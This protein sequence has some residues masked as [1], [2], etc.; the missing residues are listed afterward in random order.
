MVL[1]FRHLLIMFLLYLL[2]NILYLF[3]QELLKFLLDIR[4]KFI[5]VASPLQ[6]EIPIFLYY[7][8]I[9]KGQ[10]IGYL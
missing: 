4:V 6:V 1:L 10:V 5:M 3:S 7:F 9:S 2:G 8:P